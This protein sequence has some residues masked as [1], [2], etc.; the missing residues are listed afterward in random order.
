MH[1]KTGTPDEHYVL[2]AFRAILQYSPIS[3]EELV[4]GA[5]VMA[6]VYRMGYDAD[7]VLSV[8]ELHQAAM[9]K[10]NR[11]MESEEAGAA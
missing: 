5:Q 1:F 3:L 7:D 8:I 10:R 6:Q 4:K 11:R 2:F 9:R